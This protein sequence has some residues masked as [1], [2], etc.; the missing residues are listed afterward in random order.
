MFIHEGLNSFWG[1]RP[2][3]GKDRIWV[4]GQLVHVSVIDP[5]D[6]LREIDVEIEDGLSGLVQKRM[7]CADC[8]LA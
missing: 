5:P 2:H 3:L 8:D 6:G 7:P 4:A 1:F